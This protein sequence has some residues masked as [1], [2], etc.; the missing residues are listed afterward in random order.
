MYVFPTLISAP[1]A[2]AQAL[3]EKLAALV[4]EQRQQDPTL[5]AG[6][7]QQAFA[8]AQQ[9]LATE[10]GASATR[11]RILLAAMAALALVLGLA[12]ALLSAQPTG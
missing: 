7:V 11:A 5:E 3:A 8:V 12:F 2:R 4:R 9:Q 6:E 1:S 10:L